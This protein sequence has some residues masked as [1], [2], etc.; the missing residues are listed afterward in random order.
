VK[1]AVTPMSRIEN[2]NIIELQQVFASGKFERILLAEGDSWFDIFTPFDFVQPNL[3]H[4]IQTPWKAAVVD[5]SHVGDTAEQMVTGKQ[6]VQTA[7]FLD[8]FKFDCLLLSA[9]GNDLKD[10]FAEAYIDAIGAATRSK[11]RKP[12][13]S[14]D[15]K[16]RVANGII[17]QV[18]QSIAKWIA[19]RDSSK[20]NYATP[21][22]LHGYD[23]L[24]PRPAGARL[25]RNGLV[26]RGPWIYPVLVHAGKDDA[27]ML[28]IARGV[29]DDFN[30]ALQKRV[31]GIPNVHLLDTRNTLVPAAPRTDAQSN[32]FMDE[33]HPTPAGF[34]KLAAAAWNDKIKAVVRP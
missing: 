28:T 19:I 14:I 24:Q 16:S 12:A 6:A 11:R 18:C 1:S 15:V 25:T 27:Q 22:V 2:P 10:A 3:L 13:R 33:I 34:G 8:M 32:D 17:D 5:I 4:A 31:G 26:V 29:I 21:L 9:G 30:N 7:Q 20:M 23:Y